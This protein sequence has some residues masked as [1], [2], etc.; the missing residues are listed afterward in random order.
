MKYLQPVFL[1]LAADAARPGAFHDDLL[2][3]YIGGII[4]L[5]IYLVAVNYKTLIS[6]FRKRNR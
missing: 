5:G 2:S 3:L 4:L 6:A 1:P